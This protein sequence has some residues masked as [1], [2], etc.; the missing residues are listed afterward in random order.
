M[1]WNGREGKGREGKR[2]EGKGGEGK[3]KDIRTVRYVSFV[4]RFYLSPCGMLA[5][6]PPSLRR[7]HMRVLLG[8]DAGVRPL[9]QVGFV[10]C[11]FH[12]VRGG[13]GY[14]T[15]EISRIWPSLFLVDLPRTRPSLFVRLMTM[16]IVASI[17]DPSSPATGGATV[18]TRGT[19]FPV[20]VSR[21]SPVF[22]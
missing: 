17:A 13:G 11:I 16:D 4:F 1:E 10:L 14:L 21:P 22:W 5:P 19:A 9:P 8:H 20:R 18:T 12:C 2:R 3:R 15:F 7:Q 6:P